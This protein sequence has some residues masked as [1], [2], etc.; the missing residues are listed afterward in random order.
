VATIAIASGAAITVNAGASD[1]V[2]LRNLTINGLGGGGTGIQYNSGPALQVENVSIAKF[3]GSG[4]QG[5]LGS[6]SAFT[7]LNGGKQQRHGC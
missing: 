5:M 2:V 3:S 4:G 6:T 1:K 7:Q